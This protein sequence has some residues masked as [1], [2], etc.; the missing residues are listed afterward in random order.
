MLLWK[1]DPLVVLGIWESQVHGEAAEQSEF[2]KQG[3]ISYTQR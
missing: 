1:S 3:H 2:P